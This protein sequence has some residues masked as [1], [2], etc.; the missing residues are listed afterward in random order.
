VTREY[1]SLEALEKARMAQE[2]YSRN[3]PVQLRLDLGGLTCSNPGSTVATSGEGDAA[4]L[5]AT[6]KENFNV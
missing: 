4:L 3:T 1:Q 2:V 6:T 5:P